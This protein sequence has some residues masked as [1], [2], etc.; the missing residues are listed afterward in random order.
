MVHL[1]KRCLYNNQYNKSRL[2]D[3]LPVRVS[4]NCTSKYTKKEDHL[5]ITILLL[6][7]SGL[8][9]VF[10][11]SDQNSVLWWGYVFLQLCSALH[12][13]HKHSSAQ[14]VFILIFYAYGYHLAFAL[15][16]LR[17]KYRFFNL[18]PEHGKKEFHFIYFYITC[19]PK[20]ILFYL[21]SRLR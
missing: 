20:S 17:C 21:L 18:A 1:L 14:N 11:V 5:F 13:F 8:L 2:F 7:G 19:P 6:W 15:P 3:L 10:S 12:A 9:Q 4:N 16:I